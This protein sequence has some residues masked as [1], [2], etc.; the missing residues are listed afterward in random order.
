M[1][2][3]IRRSQAELVVRVGVPV[4][5]RC[6]SPSITV[7]KPD[8]YEEVRCAAELQFV[9]YLHMKTDGP[10]SSSRVGMIT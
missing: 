3:F 2:S 4:P 7:E 5:P 6:T 1:R 10:M 9:T 8:I